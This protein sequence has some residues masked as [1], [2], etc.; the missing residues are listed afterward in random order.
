MQQKSHIEQSNDNYLAFKT[1]F[2]QTN[3]LIFLNYHMQLLLVSIKKNIIFQFYLTP[4][5]LIHKSP[6]I[7]EISYARP[8]LVSINKKYGLTAMHAI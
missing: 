8:F 2:S 7:F 5:T 1:S 3:H 4:F 6:L